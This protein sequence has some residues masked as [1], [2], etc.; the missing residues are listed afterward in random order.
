MRNFLK[1]LFAGIFVCMAVVTVRASLAMSLWAAWD[2]YA[3]N[4]WAVATL[5]DAYCG[6]TVFF[7]W[8]FYKE[9]NWGARALWFVLIMGLG[10]IATSVYVLKELVLLRADDPLEDLLRRRP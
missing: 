10:N 7:C 2:S 6:F 1:I 9:R 4:P 5:W 8:V 3:R